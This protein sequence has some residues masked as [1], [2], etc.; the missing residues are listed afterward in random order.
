MDFFRASARS[1][2]MLSHLTAIQSYF[3]PVSKTS[4]FNINIIP[5]NF[6][7]RKGSL[8]VILLYRLFQGG[9]LSGT[10]LEI[11]LRVG[12]S[13]IPLNVPP[14][15]VLSDHSSQFTLTKSPG[16]NLSIIKL[17]G[18]LGLFSQSLRNDSL[19]NW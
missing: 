7:L 8:W 17:R 19:Q 2:F 16:G 10:I 12:I 13:V 14:R 3:Y 5:M 6:P 18:M 15:R 11:S 9:Y 1:I 4:N